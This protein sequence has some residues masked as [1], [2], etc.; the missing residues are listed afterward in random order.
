M[1][2]PTLKEKTARGILWGGVS[3]GIQQ[4]LNLFFGIFL[5]RLLT[6][7]DYGMVGMLSIF[8]LIAASLQ[9]SGFTAALANRK[10]VTHA[11]YNA[12]FW[13]S[14]SVSAALYVIL[15]FAA[16]LI[17]RFYALPELVPLARY[18]FLGF[19]IASMGVAHNAYLFRHLMVREKALSSII[20]LAVSGTVGVTM[21]Y[22]GLAYWGI[23]TQSIVYVAV[24]NV[25]Y[26]LFSPWRPTWTFDMTPLR[27]MFSF[28]SKL[29]L[30][31]IFTHLNN[32]VMA[33]L[34]GRYYDQQRVGYFAQGNKWT[35]MGHSLVTGMMNSVAQPV[36]AG[37]TDDRA[38]QLRVFRKMLRFASFAAFPAM[39]GL[40]LIARELI[41]I[42]ITEK[43]LVSAE[44]MLP[45]CVAGAFLPIQHLYSQLVVSRGTSDIFMW[46]TIALGIV[47]LLALWVLRGEG[48]TTMATAY[49]AIQIAW[50]A[51]WHFFVQRAI[52][53]TLWDAFL[54]IAPFAAIALAA[55]LLTATATSSITDIYLRFCAKVFLFAALYCVTLWALKSVTFRESLD[56]LSRRIGKK[57]IFARDEEQL[58]P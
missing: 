37:V 57:G 40:A 29:L 48:L 51:V 6:A 17:A 8:S 1:T 21:A 45:L 42:A 16:P 35:T 33:V 52:G 10:E 38:R 5:A 25:C 18:T 58:H 28:S 47:Q 55:A 15:F 32:N 9:E 34:L 4:L 44:L 3:N 36:L 12:V 7:A 50:L 30:T 11:D 23:A 56:F 20:G 53:L 2:A 49:A 24:V 46:N 39:L 31:N 22:C 14:I 43:W 19:F 13:M 26:R 27:G 54:D 41:T